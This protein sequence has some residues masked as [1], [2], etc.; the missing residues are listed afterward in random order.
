M[1][2]KKGNADRDSVSFSF[3]AWAEQYSAA[4]YWYFAGAYIIMEEVIVKEE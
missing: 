1:I 4:E 2:K 3:A